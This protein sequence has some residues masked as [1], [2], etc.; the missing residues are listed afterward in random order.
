MTRAAAAFGS[1]ALVLAMGAGCAQH[2]VTALRAAPRYDAEIRRTS[3]GIPHVK[4]ADEGSLGYG[5][6]YAYA[7]DN[8]CLLA[9]QIVTASGERS[10]FF[11]ATGKF[12]QRVPN[13]RSDTLYRWL[14]GNGSIEAAWRAQPDAVRALL[15]GYAAGVNR[16]L[17]D[18]AT[19]QRPAACAGAPWLRPV[20]ALDLM[21][22]SRFYTVSSGLGGFAESFGVARPA[23]DSSATDPVQRRARRPAGDRFGSNAVAIGR[24]LAAAGGGMLLG[25][26]HLEWDGPYRFWQLHATIPGKLDVMGASLPGYPGVQIGFNRHVAWSHTVDTSA[27]YVLYRLKLDPADPTRYIVDGKSQPMKKVDVP[28]DVR[29]ADGTI[30][31]EIQ[32]VYETSFGPLMAW[33]GWLLWNR[34]IA[35]ALHDPNRDNDRALVQWLEMGEAT[36][37]QAFRRAIEVRMGIPWVNTIAADDRGTVLYLNVSVIPY[38]DA[39]MVAQCTPGPA[40][41]EADEK[42]F[43]LDGSRSACR[44]RA[45]AATPQPGIFPASM[46]PALERTDFVQN[47]NDSAWFTNP[48]QPLV[49][50]SPFVSRQGLPLGGRTRFAL[51]RLTGDQRDGRRLDVERLRNLVTDNEVYFSS[52]VIDD[53]KRLCTQSQHAQ[54]ADGSLVDTTKACAALAAWDRTVNLEAGQGY[55]YFKA[56]MEELRNSALTW[57][58]PFDERDPIHTPRGLRLDDAQTR[59]ALVDA[60]AQAAKKVESSGVA[61][62]ARW[63]DIQFAVQGRRQIP[64]HGG[65]EMLGIYNH[66]GSEPAGDGRL[67]VTD[68]ATYLQAVRFGSDGPQATGFLVYS[69]SANPDSPHAAD[70]TE[71]FSGKQWIAFPFSDAQIL[72]DRNYVVRR[73]IQRY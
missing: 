44:P 6:G 12:R 31:T 68:G 34:E 72:A 64:M 21:R 51:E 4:A 30:E 11:G 71:R 40:G 41:A 32:T 59:T 38:V 42:V 36:S 19:A 67:R 24:D 8:L 13:L 57:A 50:Y 22:L 47:S 29:Q 14:D 48:A 63:G 1:I 5:I 69:Q 46:L 26:P 9:E 37:L 28:V 27:H 62:D 18:T 61:P 53:L 52:L 60:L 56:F 10:K 49:G 7:E 25:N 16:F 73:L 2:P 23:M 15:Q 65:D 45:D 58:V 70:Q 33:P 39:K 35:Y 66:M 55:L 20:T 17:A 54:T 3:F 43:M